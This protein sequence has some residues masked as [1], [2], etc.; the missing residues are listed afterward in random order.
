M[1]DESTLVC[2]PGPSVA[3]FYWLRGRVRRRDGEV[4][5]RAEQL[6]LVPEAPAPPRRP[7]HPRAREWPIA[8]SPPFL[9]A[10]GPGPAP[11]REP[12]AL[13]ESWEE[14]RRRRWW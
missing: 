7:L 11:R 13:P 1:P 6:E 5:Q 8:E 3:A 4:L 2:G 12:R 9:A 14:Y 10:L